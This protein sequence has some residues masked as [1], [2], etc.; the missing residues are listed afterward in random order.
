MT[1]QFAHSRLTDA[2]RW[3]GAYAEIVIGARGDPER[4]KRVFERSV[5]PM[6]MLNNER[7]YLDANT[8]ARLAFRQSLAELRRLRLDD[9]TPEYFLPVMETAWARLIEAG[10]VAGPYD[11]GSPVGT[12][13][14][15]SYYALADALP[16]AHLI[17]FAPADWP[18]GELIADLPAVGSVPTLTPRE[19]EILSLAADGHTGPA[20]AAALVVS[21]ATVKTHFQHIYAKLDV[22]DRAAAV[23]KAMRLGLIV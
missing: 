15:V 9:L 8:P 23:A 17:A 18:D 3:V 5:V 10:C 14:R 1:H 7:R 16:G 21:P 4:L 13:L 2:P 6:L 22:S 11:F 20:I 19:L 12:H